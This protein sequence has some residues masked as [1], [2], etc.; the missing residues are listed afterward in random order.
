MSVKAERERLQAEEQSLEDLRIA[1]VRERIRRNM[2][3]ERAPLQWRQ[4]GKR[5]VSTDGRFAIE[6]EGKK[7]AARYTAKLLMITGETV[8]GHRLFTYEA[9][10]ELCCNH[11][12][13][14]PLEPKNDVSPEPKPAAGTHLREREPGEDD[15]SPQ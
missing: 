3:T 10:K 12:S 1:K 15:E 9:A 6:K 8:I 5:M 13:P 11:A 7:D 2:P 14:L 4:T